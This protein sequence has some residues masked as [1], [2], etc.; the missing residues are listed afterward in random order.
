[1]ANEYEELMARAQDLQTK[2]AAAQDELGRMTLRGV[3][4]NGQIIVDMD[5]KYNCLAI[6]IA[7]ELLAEGVPTVAAVIKSAFDDAKGKTDTAID[8]V[9]SVATEG[10][11]I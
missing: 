4:S 8:K 3:A 5:G 9:M 7:P 2:V 10:M 6:T 1:M 11:P